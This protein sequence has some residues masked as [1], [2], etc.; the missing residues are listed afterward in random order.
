MFNRII[1]FVKVTAVLLLLVVTTSL[2]L[3]IMMPL[4][5]LKLCLPFKPVRRVCDP[6]I[7]G[8]AKSWNDCNIMWMGGMGHIKWHMEGHEGF[9]RK[10]WYLVSCNHQSWV[11]ILVLQ[12]VFNSRIPLLKFFIKYEL[13]FVP[14][15]GLGWWALDFPFM[16]RQ[17]GASAQK[18]LEV[19]RKACEKFRVIPTSV[20]S[21]AEGTRFTQAKHDQQKSP[22]TNLLKPKVGGI[23]MALSTMGDMFDT[24]IDVTIIYP[25]GVP[26]FTDLMTGKLEEVVVSVRALPIPKELLVN[27]QGQ[28]ASR[29]TMQTWLNEMW[30]GKDQQITELK[31]RFKAQS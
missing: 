1:S 26:T 6:V 28:P 14:L 11:D 29:A 7:N 8:I 20:I 17:G 5:L 3:T 2:A 16:K 15:V 22:Y 13:L 10:G 25:R 19:A 12:K 30:Q 31:Q 4:A 9:Q 18:D 23:G 27:A 24:M 21:F